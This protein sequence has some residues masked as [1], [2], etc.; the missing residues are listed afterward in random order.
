[1]TSLG[2]KFTFLFLQNAVV[3][4]AREALDEFHHQSLAET[5]F[6]CEHENLDGVSGS[7]RI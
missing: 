4:K 6:T 7:S 1:M 2:T 5:N 3:H